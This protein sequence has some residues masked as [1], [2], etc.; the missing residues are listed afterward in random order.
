MK[1]AGLGEETTSG[2]D[3]RTAAVDLTAYID[4]VVRYRWTFVI[5]I[6]LTVAAGVLYAVLSRPIYRSDIVV[7][8]E[9]SRS[10]PAA[11]S[12]NSTFA[13]LFNHKPVANAEVELLRSRMIV[14]KAVDNL[15]LHIE[16]TPRYFPL[17]GKA[18]ASFRTG[19]SVPGLFGWGGFAWGNESI[20]VDR[21][22]T[23]ATMEGR[24]I[25]L[26]ALGHGSYKVEFSSDNA[27]ATG[28]IG[29]PLS[30]ETAAGT[31]N[32]LVSDISGNPG[33]RYVLR[34]LAR[35]DAIAQL[36]GS[37]NISERGKESGV[38][39]ISLEGTSPEKTAAIL[40]D[41]GQAYV[42]Q[43]VRRMAEE[44]EN[45]LSFLESQ[46]PRLRQQAEAAES[47]YN[48]TRNQRGTVDL[49]EE[50]KLIL[51]QSV[52]IQTKLQELRQ[53]RQELA[54]RFTANHPSIGLVD[55][56]IA[57]LTAQLNEVSARIR[58][59]P[60]V[61]QQVLR[62]MQDVKVST[63]TLKSLLND[64]QQLRLMKASKV[65]NAR[66]IDP[67][68]VPIKP[69]RPNPGMIVMFSLVLG[70]V[71]GVV[72]V[73]VR[74][75]M[76]GGV[77]D[78]DEI[79]QQTGMT[80]YGTIPFSLL[81]GH[82]EPVGEAAGTLL[83]R[84]HPDDPATE[85]L[86]NFRTALQFALAS[87]KRRIVAFTGPSPG[88]GKSFVCANFAA[89]AS[90]G[91]RVILVDAD[92]RRGRLHQ[93]FSQPRSPGLS[94]L[95]M[96]APMDRVV[97]HEVAPGLDFIPTGSEPP[98]AADLLSGQEMLKLLDHLSSRYDLVLLDTPPVLAASDAAILASKADAV[99]LVARADTTTIDEL[100]SSQRELRQAGAEVKGVLFNGLNVEGR[101][102][103]SHYYFG[104]YRYLSHYQ[105]KPKRA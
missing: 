62:S 105:Q 21:L 91:R 63:D 9:Q 86:R 93:R 30:I 1:T 29:H 95:L 97:R 26:T 103:R 25:L 42:D 10:D 77:A 58:K 71:G 94:E 55:S 7:Q 104:K 90:T 39:G 34:R 99:F 8:L 5:T 11:P 82:Q 98:N 57:S 65:G 46:L 53:R 23:P 28:S 69:V 78:A 44:A 3:A 81:Q 92:L 100:M 49:G 83:A 87:S 41:I 14:G 20:V 76:D 4:V 67:A 40:N 56:Q 96:G 64:V 36:Q 66:L 24:K 47:K 54:A 48:A 17:L 2:R 27:S 38:I 13:P 73:I 85:S 12:L 74:H 68:E 22:D 43:N 51:A 37:L 35:N 75:A 60:D 19:L 18:I 70:V 89:I 88:V 61:E 101:W 50:S 52:Q 15:R 33:T 31:V 79:E 32:L 80:V 59:V 72:L 45:S 6:V 102:Y 84:D 16:A